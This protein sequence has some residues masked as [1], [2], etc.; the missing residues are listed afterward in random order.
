MFFPFFI[1]FSFVI[2]DSLAQGNLVPNPSF[3]I[4][5]T[6]PGDAY[7]NHIDVASGWQPI[8]LS[9][10]Y[11]NICSNNLWS[12]IPKNIGGFQGPSSIADSAYVGIGMEVLNSKREILGVKL[13]APLQ[14][15]VRYFISF[16]AISGFKDSSNVLFK[17]TCF[18]NKI[19][20]KLLLDT[21]WTSFNEQL[22]NNNAQIYSNQ[23]ISDTLNWSLVQGSFVA[24]SAYQYLMVGNF[25]DNNNI[26]SSC[27]SNGII[28]YTF[29]DNICI[30]SDSSECM[31][32]TN[33]NNIPNPP[34]SLIA[35]VDHL[36][37]IINI[38][39]FGSKYLST[40][41]KIFNVNGQLVYS[42]VIL[43]KH[44]VIDCSSWNSG[45][46]LL[47]TESYS[48]KLLIY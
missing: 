5:D 42:N 17:F 24:D 21:V 28:A 22:I 2:H 48:L 10:D 34:I 9:P 16:Q 6:C 7:H 35:N 29:I 20:V 14:I 1:L 15:G 45:L 41:F 47:S 12:A 11:F 26:L 36:N 33:T 23:I 31:L 18:C 32:S 46:Y 38:F 37:H 19:G 8:N 25:F 4:H 27:Y 3:E 44:T 40:N 30:S 39:S 43:E 13:L